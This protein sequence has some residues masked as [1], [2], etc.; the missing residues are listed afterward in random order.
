MALEVSLRDQLYFA[1]A[2]EYILY[3]LQKSKSF[4]S[5]TENKT[6]IVAT[7]RAILAFF[8]AVGLTYHFDVEQHQFIVGNIRAS[9]IFI[10]LYN[11]FGQYALQHGFGHLIRGGN[12][13]K[14]RRIV[15]SEVISALQ[16]YLPGVG[17]GVVEKEQKEQDAN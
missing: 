11:W 13:D 10:G 3:T 8:A 15:R 4:P 1:A 17:E 6:R 7:T 12:L 9:V 2:M 16:P 5:I 14:F